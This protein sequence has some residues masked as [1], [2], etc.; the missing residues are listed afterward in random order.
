MSTLSIER[1]SEL[2]GHWAALWRGDFSRADEILDPG[3]VVHQARPDGS[4]SE[5]VTGSAR[6]LPEIEQTMAVFDDVALTVDV[7]PIV[8]GDL[9]AA[10]WTLRARYT[11]GL[12]HATAPAGTPVEFSGHDILRVCG[13]RFVE[14]WTCTDVLAGLAR[15]GA[16][17]GPNGPARA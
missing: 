10:R 5:A 13:G 4:D 9:I 7:G 3:F 11:G 1:M 15:L 6:L 8:Q 17:S 16:V 14:Y 2:Y 12:E